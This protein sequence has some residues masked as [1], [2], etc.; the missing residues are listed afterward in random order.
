MQRKLNIKLDLGVDLKHSPGQKLY[1]KTDMPFRP[2]LSCPPKNS[3]VPRRGI[4][5]YREI[6]RNSG[7]MEIL[8]RRHLMS[9]EPNVGKTTGTGTL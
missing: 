1:R 3:I 9:N 8:N 4:N 5:I 7:I 6:P 2:R